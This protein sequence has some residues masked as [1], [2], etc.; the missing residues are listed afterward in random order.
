MERML[1]LRTQNYVDSLCQ[2]FFWQG[3]TAPGELDL[4]TKKGFGAK[5]RSSGEFSSIE[6]ED[7]ISLRAAVGRIRAGGGGGAKKGA[8]NGSV[9]QRGDRSRS[10]SNRK[11][12][13][14]GR[15]RA[16]SGNG[17]RRNN[18]REQRNNSR[19]HRNN[20]NDKPEH[21]NKSEPKAKPE[22]WEPVERNDEA[23]VQGLLMQGQNP[24]E[25]HE[26][27]TPLMKAAG[28][29]KSRQ[30]RNNSRPNRKKD[31]DKPQ[32]HNKSEP[33]AKPE[34]WKAVERNDKA[35][36]QELLMQ[37]QDPEEK[38]QNWTPLM[39]AAELNSAEVM[40]MLLEKHVDVEACNRNG[41][42]ALS[43]AAAPSMNGSE[44]RETAVATLR[45]LLANGADP[46]RKDVRGFTA[47]D[48]A[49]KEKRRDAMAVFEDFG[50]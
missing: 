35:A 36:V 13:G 39:K 12:R 22:S 24:E 43:F 25:K 3:I 7:A 29:K 1:P 26:G 42:T 45:I 14:R 48:W 18:S 28:R 37:G 15:E 34:L 41:R 9:G 20:G 16:N 40:T 23:A 44:R 33:K 8:G 21:Q 50:A 19:P 30:H 2:K 38:H 27:G 46:T 11:A 32:H 10:R 4:A 31:K 17:G 5:L 49:S 47:K 6:M